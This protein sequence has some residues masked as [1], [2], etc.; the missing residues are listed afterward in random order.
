MLNKVFRTVSNSAVTSGLL[1]MFE[2]IDNHSPRLL[3]VL[4]YHRVTAPEKTPYQYPRV[5]VRPEVFEQHMR[6]LKR[7]YRVISMAEVLESLATGDPLPEL[8]V[9][10]TFDDAYRDF[11]D[12]AVPVLQHYHLPATL[13][14][15]T[16][17]PDHPERTFWWDK[18][19]A[20]IECAAN[21]EII[22]TP[23]GLLPVATAA[24]RKNTFSR[25]RDHVKT[26]PHQAAMDWVNQ[27]CEELEAPTTAGNVLSWDELRQLA[28]AGITLGAHTRTH[29]MMDQISSDE[30]REEAVGSW[31]DLQNNVGETLP[32]FAF[33]SGG[34]NQKVLQILAEEGFQIA[35]TTERGINDLRKADR[36]Q[37]KRINV[38]PKTTLPLLRAQ[39]LSWMKPYRQ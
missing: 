20:A 10:I 8:A 27:F 13:F 7:H 6:F 39:L 29:P 31:Q 9:L 12:N 37:L 17:F 1:S 32:I 28:S 21:M 30:I 26:T 34:Y 18:L 19:H 5:T 4:T 24:Q 2:R 3:R 16:A 22:R 36:L 14:V 35:F 25:L 15:P 33:P 23:L 11:A 38:G